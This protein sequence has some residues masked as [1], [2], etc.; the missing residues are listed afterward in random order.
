MD[1]INPVT[2]PDPRLYTGETVWRREEKDRAKPRPSAKCEEDEDEVE[3]EE[4]KG[5]DLEA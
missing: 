2:P 3:P 4:E 5:L 1:G